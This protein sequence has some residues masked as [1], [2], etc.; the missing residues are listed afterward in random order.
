MKHVVTG[1]HSLPQPVPEKQEAILGNRLHWGLAGQQ[2]LVALHKALDNLR[3]AVIER[4]EQR[5]DLVAATKTLRSD[6]WRTRHCVVTRVETEANH[7]MLG[8]HAP[9][10][11]LKCLGHLGSL[12]GWPKCAVFPAMPT[13]TAIA[14]QPSLGIL[15]ELGALAANTQVADLESVAV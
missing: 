6:C 11:P 10:A 15:H 8:Q 13:A 7:S 1:K 9:K 2:F 12:V 14:D 5:K 3:L 4:G